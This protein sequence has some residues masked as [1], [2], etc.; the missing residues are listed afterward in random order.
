[1]V[2]NGNLTRR[3]ITEAPGTI[4]K[5]CTCPSSRGYVGEVH[6]NLY[7]LSIDLVLLSDP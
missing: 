7:Y 1:M 5:D 2:S 4:H 3:K 6:K